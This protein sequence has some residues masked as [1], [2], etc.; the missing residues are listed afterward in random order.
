MIPFLQ[1]ANRAFRRLPTVQSLRRFQRNKGGATAIEFAALAFPFFLLLFAII[2]CS[3]FFFAGQL[4]ES[5]VDD[6]GRRVRTG[7]LD[8]SMT[9]SQFKAAICT[10]TAILFECGKL[11]IDLKVA[12]KFED[13]QDPPT[14]VAGEID[15][16]KYTFTPP[17]PEQIAMITVT[18]TWP[19]FTNYVAAHLSKLND[20]SALLNALAVFR[21]EPYPAKA[22]GAAC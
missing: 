11:K 15:E 8:N 10:E 6:V 18:Y 21:T 22:G 16:S 1:I 20:G 3:L 2:E 9:E 5:A 19:V 13:L 12:A 7:Q 17:C 14:P 4:L